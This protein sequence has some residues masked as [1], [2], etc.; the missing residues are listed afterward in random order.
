[1]HALE[2]AAVVTDRLTEEWRDGLERGQFLIQRCKPCGTYQ[3]YPREHC[4]TSGSEVEWVPSSGRG[5][6]HTYTVIRRT[7]NEEFQDDLPYVLGIVEL[8][9]GVRV[10]TRIVT[11]NI[12]RVECGMPV[13]V[14]FGSTREDLP[15]FVPV[16]PE[17]S[18]S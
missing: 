3:Y 12:D 18:I 16:D 2:S 9:E 13:A 14:R 7:P 11:L 15:Y 6:V 1:M 17:E 8:E 10:T 4:V 5:V